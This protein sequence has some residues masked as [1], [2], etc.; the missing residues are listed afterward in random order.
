MNDLLIYFIAA[1]IGYFF[2]TFPTGF[3][4]AKLWNVDVRKHG[5][6]RTGGTNVLR[7]VGWVGFLLTG[8]G[9]ILK[10]SLAV[11]LSRFLFPAQDIAHSITVYSVLLGH[12]WSLWLLLLARPDP[13]A[14]NPATPSEGFQRLLGKARGGAG[15]GPTAGAMLVLFPPLVLILFP[16]FVVILFAFRYASV[17]SVSLAALT[18]IVMLGF[19]LTGY[20]PDTFFFL[21]LA[22]GIT[23]LLVHIPNLQRLR[24]GTEKKFGQR[25][26]Q[27]TSRPTDDQL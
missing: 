17:A 21:A 1:L 10:G 5:S 12:N 26:G 24:A 4:V 20:A 11:L 7:S 23:I 14:A 15:I 3:F 19:C 6:G 18:P 13:R 9:D 16:V 8:L 2:G 27:R 25:L 22:L